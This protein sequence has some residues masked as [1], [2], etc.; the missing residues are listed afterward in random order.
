[1]VSLIFVNIGPGASDG[2]SPV[3]HQVNTWTYADELS[4]GRKL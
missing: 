2:F 4:V 1:M 3:W